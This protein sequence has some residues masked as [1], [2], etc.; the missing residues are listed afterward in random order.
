LLGKP[1]NR[2]R[3]PHEAGKWLHDSRP[4][5]LAVRFQIGGRDLDALPIGPAPQEVA[6]GLGETDRFGHD[7]LHAWMMCVFFQSDYTRGRYGLNGNPSPALGAPPLTTSQP[8]R[9]VVLSLMSI[10]TSYNRMYVVLDHSITR[11]ETV[12]FSGIWILPYGR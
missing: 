3:S 9:P 11:A 2:F 7:F 5:Q 10:F 8:Q 6:G 4:G 12:N 1:E